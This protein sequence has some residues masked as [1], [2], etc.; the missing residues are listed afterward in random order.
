MRGQRVLGRVPNAEGSCAQTCTGL[1]HT[2]LLCPFPSTLA[3]LLSLLSGVPCHPQ[4]RDSSLGTDLFSPSLKQ[5][6]C[7][8]WAA[9]SQ[10]GRQLLAWLNVGRDV[11]SAPSPLPAPPSR[12]R[13]LKF[14]ELEIHSCGL[15]CLGHRVTNVYCRC[16]KKPT[17]CPGACGG[18]MRR[19]KTVQRVADGL[20]WRMG[21]SGGPARLHSS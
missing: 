21:A 4:V 9:L 8:P 10:L 6:F 7:V 14:A 15:F 1:R 18:Q 3:P 12:P 5:P 16:I 13:S 19:H 2:W 17:H 20:G 11:A